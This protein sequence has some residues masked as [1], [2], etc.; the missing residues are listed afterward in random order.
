MASVEIRTVDH[1]T[2]HRRVV[3]YSP[4]MLERFNQQKLR[5]TGKWHVDKT[6]IKVRGRWTYLYRATDSNSGSVKFRFNEQRN[7]TAAVRFLCK[8]LERHGQL[9]RIVIDGSQ[10][11]REAIVSCDTTD[12]LQDR[13]RRDPN[14][15]RARQS[16]FLNTRVEQ[17]HRAIKRSAANARLSVRR[18]RP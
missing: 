13:A 14:L 3:S 7:L 12:R 2:V 6:Y 9:E 1:A 4:E 17:D 15:I 5:I 16:D 8:A 11:N 10:T 18:Q